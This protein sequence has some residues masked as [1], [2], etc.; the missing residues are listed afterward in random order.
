[1]KRILIFLLSALL[2]LSVS[3]CSDNSNEV[4]D[5]SATEVALTVKEGVTFVDDMFEV[6]NEV[7][8]DFYNLPEGVTDFKVYMSASGATAEE[9]AVFKCDSKK[10]SDEVIKACEKRTENLTE[11]FE[12]YIPEELTK[13]KSAVIEEK[14]GF[15]MFICAD[16]TEPAEEK[17]KDYKYY[18]ADN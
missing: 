7:V 18:R 13:I 12:D 3:A 8:P 14:N 5:A 1:M 4:S 2:I 9:L 11:K 15:V 6:S 17:F 16:S 10:T